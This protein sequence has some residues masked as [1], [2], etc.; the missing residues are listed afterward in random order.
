[1]TVQSP[2]AT[3]PVQPKPAFCF[4][5]SHHQKLRPNHRLT[6]CCFS[7]LPN[8]SPVALF[9]SLLYSSSPSSCSVLC[10]HLRPRCSESATTPNR[11]YTIDPPAASIIATRDATASD[12]AL[13]RRREPHTSRGSDILSISSPHLALNC[14]SGPESPLTV[15]HHEQPTPSN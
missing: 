7:S 9:L 5:A 4:A 3:R 15:A 1:M 10:I 11:T 2:T 8:H 12:D 13:W 6:H 14:P